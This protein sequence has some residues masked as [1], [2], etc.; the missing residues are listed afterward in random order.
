MAFAPLEES[1]EDGQPIY[2]YRFSLN[3]KV[4]RYTSADGNIVRG[5]DTWVA[6]PIGD[7]G[8]RQTGEATSDA[9]QITTSTASCVPAQLYMEY[10]PATPVQLAV[11]ITHED[12]NEVKAIYVGEITNCNV[13]QPGSAILMCETFAATMRR[14]GLRLGWQRNC[15]YALYDVV[16]CKVP[17]ATWG[18]TGTVSAVEDNIVTLPALEGVVADG[19]MRGGFIEWID[20]VRGVERRGI[21]AQVGSAM[22]MFGAADG[23][24]VGLAVTAYPGCPRNV[25]GCQSFNNYDNYGG[26]PALKGKSPFDGDPVF[27]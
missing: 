19:R 16:T 11:Y 26:V 3:D 24:T 18:I 25:A 27:N 23:I 20:P 1:L 7:D 22:L 10:P 17:K 6:I 15:P 4:W 9:L 13:P 8:P 14:E 12:D 21:E 5:A 2:L